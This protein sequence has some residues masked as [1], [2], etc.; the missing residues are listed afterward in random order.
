MSIAGVI[1]L[2]AAGRGDKGTFNGE[3][4]FGTTTHVTLPQPTSLS[5]SVRDLLRAPCR[6]CRTSSGYTMI[7]LRPAS[8]L[9]LLCAL[10]ACTCTFVA[11]DEITANANAPPTLAAQSDEYV[12]AMTSRERSPQAARQQARAGFEGCSHRHGVA[13]GPR[14]ARE[15]G[16]RCRR[17]QAHG[18]ELRLARGRG[19][20]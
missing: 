13:R 11:A 14:A 2:N 19:R 17:H 18:R 4:R 6:A 15:G 20:P 12:R 9:L 1:C 7:S 10:F 5:Y 3:R 8:L 16:P